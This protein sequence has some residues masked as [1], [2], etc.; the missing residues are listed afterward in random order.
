MVSLKKKN[1]YKS[2]KIRI[3]EKIRTEIRTMSGNTGVDTF[4]NVAVI[5]VCP[6]QRCVQFAEILTS[7]LLHF[8]IKPATHYSRTMTKKEQTD[9]ICASCE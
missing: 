5:Y 4:R 2:P 3:F 6:R 8:R 1:P 7:P 9:K